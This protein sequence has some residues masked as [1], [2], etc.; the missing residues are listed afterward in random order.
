MVPSVS[1]SF[2]AVDGLQVV[3]GDDSD[4]IRK[5]GCCLYVAD[6]LLFVPV[7]VNF[8]NVAVVFLADLDIYIVAVYR[9]PFCTA[10]QGE[11]LLLFLSEFC[12]G[13]EILLLGDFNLPSLAWRLENVMRG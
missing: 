7:E 6:S 10:L 11:S 2:I 13:R 12:I 4:S 9:P 8:F 1:S 5:R 3:R